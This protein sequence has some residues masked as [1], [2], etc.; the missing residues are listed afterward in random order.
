MSDKLSHVQQIRFTDKQRSFLASQQGTMSE[1]V[2]ALIDKA[3]ASPCPACKGTGVLAS[4]PASKVPLLTSLL[5]SPVYLIV[6][7]LQGEIYVKKPIG[8]T[9]RTVEV[10]NLAQVTW[11]IG[12][13]SI[14]DA[15]GNEW[16][17]D[18]HCNYMC[19]RPGDSITIDIP[20]I[21]G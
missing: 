12:S 5:P 2:R 8:K 3:S 16:L 14:T 21:E 7:N 9:D 11:H 19:V 10:T 15:K 20:T 13:V 17:V 18:M 4:A 6:R 1:A